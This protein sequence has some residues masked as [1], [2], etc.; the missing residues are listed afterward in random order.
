M[1]SQQRLMALSREK[2][3]KDLQLKAIRLKA[4]PHFHSNV[5][6]SIEYF[7]MNNSSDEASHYLKLYSDFTN[8]TLSDIDRPARTVDE[9]VSYIAAYLE[10]E[11][12]RYGDRLQYN[13]DIESE[14]NPQTLLPTMLLHTYCQNA[15][16]HG[17]GGRNEG[18]FVKVFISRQRRHGVDGT[19]VSVS[20]DGIGRQAAAQGN[21]D[22]TRQGLKILM[23][24]T[25]LYNEYNRNKMEHGVIDL[26]DEA[27]RPAGTRFET[28]VPDGF[29][30]SNP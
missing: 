21:R 14:V 7:V 12:L 9:E 20:D 10:L 26:T 23:E 11:G 2:K 30:F 24:Q 4:I 13:V 25:E 6:A 1:R 19:L 28:W 16:K 15:V 3:Q 27:G 8:Q 29:V 5:M 22:S 18:G 17:I